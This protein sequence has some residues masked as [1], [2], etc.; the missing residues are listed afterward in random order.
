ML[1]YTEI[2]VHTHP[3]PNYI[4]IRISEKMKLKIQSVAKAEKRS[5]AAQAS[6]LLEMGIA[7]HER[8][9][10]IVKADHV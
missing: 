7:E 3:M 4:Q 2:R 1:D 6:I 8:R 9:E 10:A 5:L